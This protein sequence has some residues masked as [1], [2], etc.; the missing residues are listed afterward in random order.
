MIDIA[1]LR[2]NPETI[3]KAL[4]DRGGRTISNFEALV[5]ADES[6]RK[7]LAESETLRAERNACSQAFGKAKASGNSKEAEGL[8]L[9]AAQIKSALEKLERELG[10]SE[11][12]RKELLLK[13]PNLP[14]ES[15]PIGRGEQDNV[16]CREVGNKPAFDFKPLDHQ[17]V[18]EKL[19]ILDFAAAAKLAGARF[20]LW[21]GP[22]SK[23]MR[24]LISYMLDL[25][26]NNHGY[27][28][29]WPPYLVRSNIVE[30]TGQLQFFKENMYSTRCSADEEKDADEMYLIPTAEIPLTNLVREQI[31]S[32]RDLP[33]RFVAYTPCFRQEAGSYG[34][35]TR[36]LIRNHQFD[37]VELVWITE[38]EKSLEALETLTR[39]AETI[40]SSLGLPYR[41]IE[42]CTGDLG[43]ASRKTY[44]I[45]VW[46]PSENR[47]REISSCSDCGSFQA[48]R[49]NARF[50][51]DAKSAPEFV[52]TLNGSGVAAGR[53]FAA[54]LENFQTK[55]GS[56]EIPKALQ[57]FFGSAVI[58]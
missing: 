53:L 27:L 12:S 15:V 14:H 17:T 30:G 43:S 8:G 9:K 20:A 49:M 18:G 23:L 4:Q 11:A 7:I 42:L 54:I 25:H 34:K 47:Y 28:E 58:S 29:I 45:E 16:V 41:V 36:G 50:R 52:H 1:L 44:D 21:K 19:G 40:L 55:T 3:R 38:P 31:L 2:K 37:K 22:G 39:N 26:T 24:A 13:I 56:V 46:M 32:A 51:R 35:D 48:R 57:Q 33:L 10:E 6:Y 5:K